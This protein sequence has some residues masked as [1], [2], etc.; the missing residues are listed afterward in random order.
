MEKLGYIYL[1]QLGEHGPVKIGYSSD[2]KK[3]L[4]ALQI[5]AA[6]PVYLRALVA[7]AHHE[8]QALHRKYDEFRLRGE[9]FNPSD[10][11]LDELMGMPQVD[12]KS[13]VPLRRPRKKPMEAAEAEA[14]WR[15]K[16]VPQVE[17]IKRMHGWTWAR[18][19]DAF[20]Y[21]NGT[22]NPNFRHGHSTEEAKAYGKLGGLAKK[23]SA[24]ATRTPEG[25]ARI[26]WHGNNHL[27]NQQVLALPDMAGWSVTLAY[28]VLKPRN[29]QTGV[30]VGRP[31]K[32]RS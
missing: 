29:R 6:E 31:R 26:A 7:G 12:P 3:R 17:A 2:P 1:I 4:D 8:E 22:S 23:V 9:W 21:R 27:T 15:D 18:A 13:V 16:S 24:E 30:R 32:T 19:R 25:V 28:R 11:M 14:I 5:G 20:G 10:D